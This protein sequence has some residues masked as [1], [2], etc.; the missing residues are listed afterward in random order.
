[1]LRVQADSGYYVT[2][3]YRRVLDRVGYMIASVEDLHRANAAV[4]ASS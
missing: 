3:V 4:A 2:Y 1:M